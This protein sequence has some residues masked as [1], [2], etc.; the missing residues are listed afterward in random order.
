MHCQFRDSFYQQINGLP[1]RTPLSSQLANINFENLEN[2]ALNSYFVKHVYWG[3]IK[4]DVISLWN[5][6]K[7]ELWVSYIILIL[8]IKICSLP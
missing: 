8:R 7:V 5:Y 1:M 4:D 6:G 3:R 2:W